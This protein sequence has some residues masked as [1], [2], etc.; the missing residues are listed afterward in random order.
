LAYDS[1]HNA[2]MKL[3]AAGPAGFE[4]LVRDVL[5]EVSGSTFRL[6]KSGPQ[7]GVDAVGEPVA[8][9]LAIGIEGKRY[10]ATTRLP[11]DALKS[12]L[13]D[14]AASFPALDL[15]VLATTRP[16]DGGD[17]RALREI[18]AD[19]GL[20]A[21][22]LDWPEGSAVPPPL[23]ILCA[24]APTSTAH[25]LPADP[26]V[27]ADLARVREDGFYLA[28]LERLRERL[29]DPVI[30]LAATRSK[31]RAWVRERLGDAAS[32]R[33]AFDSAAVLEKD[34]VKRVARPAIEGALDA[35]CAAPV[36]P[37]ALLG[38]EGMG[39]TWALF[40]WW[41]GKVDADPDFPLTVVLPAKDVDTFDAKA[42][43]AR[44]LHRATGVRDAAFWERRVARWST[45][46][47]DRPVILLAVDG[48][49]QNWRFLGWSDLVT[50]IHTPAWLGRIAVILTCRPDHWENRLKSLTDL[51][52]GVDVVQV[53][54]FDDA[55][56]DA[57]L[58]RHGLSRA[59][60]TPA[61]LELI[62]RPRLSSIAIER[63][64]ALS[65]GGEVT[66]ERLVYEDWR[67]RHP[68]AQRAMSHGEF[69]S[70]VTE[71]GRSTSADL[72]RAPLSRGELLSR[73][74]VDGG[75]PSED[76]QV[77]LSELVDGDWL[78]YD[79]SPHRFRLRAERVPAALG[80]TLVAD[81][82][83]AS[84]PEEA[85][86][87]FA[88]LL[89][90][91][92]D[93]DLAVSILRNA[94]TFAL[95]D[96][97]VAPP[98]KLLLLQR[99]IGAQNFSP[100][101]FEA[102]WRLLG[103]APDLALDVAEVDWF[104]EHGHSRADEVLV[105]GFGNAW[106]WTEVAGAVRSRLLDWFSRYWLD[107]LQGEVLGR[108]DGD[109]QA[110]ERREASRTRARAAER[111]RV[112]ERF[113][114]E[115]KLVEPD[116]QAWG[117]YRGVELLSWLPRAPLIDVFT[118]WAITRAIIGEFRQFGAMA[119]VLRW[120]EEDAAEAERAVLERARQLLDGG[121][122]IGREAARLLLDALATPAASQL[123]D[124]E[125]G[126]PAGRAPARL[127]WQDFANDRSR[128]QPLAA[129]ATLD[130]DPLDPL[131][132]L[133]SAWV[134]H[135]KRLASLVPDAELVA[136]YGIEA[137]GLEY[138]RA[139][140][141]RWVPDDLA[142][143]VRRRFAAAIRLVPPPAPER[144][145]L[146]RLWSGARG[147][148]QEEWPAL[149]VPSLVKNLPRSLLVLTDEDLAPWRN[150][151]GR[152]L[153]EGIKAPFALHATALAGA[154]AA[155]QIALLARTMPDEGLPDWS[156][157]LLAGPEQQDL[158]AIADLLGPE[159]P[160]AS[161][162]AW[163][164]Y[165]GAA[166]RGARPDGWAPLVKLFEHDDAA[167]RAAVL[168]LVA[169]HDDQVSAEAFYRSDWRLR[170]GMSRDE[171][172]YGSVVLTIAPSANDGSVLDR[173]HPDVLGS[174]LARHPTQKVYLDAFA[175]HVRL[176]LE[177]LRTSRS[178]VYPRSLLTVPR[179]WDE[180]IAARGDD[181]IKWMRPF[182]ENE[183]GL[184]DLLFIPE[185]FPL[186][187]SF[188]AVEDLVPGAKAGVVARALKASMS[189][190]M[191]MGALYDLATEVVGPGADGARELALAEANND[192][193]LFEL[194][195]GLQRNGQGEWLLEQI[196]RDL[197]GHTSG[198]VARGL[199][200][201]GFL[202]PSA[203]NDEWWAAHQAPLATGW[204]AEVHAAAYAE[205][206]RY[207]YV[208]HWARTYRNDVDDVAAFSAHALLVA[209]A[210][211][212]LLVGEERPEAD[213]IK[214][215]PWRRRL[216]WSVGWKDV[217]AAMKKREGSF[218][219]TFLATEPPLQNQT[220][221]RQ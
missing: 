206:R 25:H 105:K 61:L 200:L 67:H 53:P 172:A 32:A 214:G 128:S 4:G 78:E 133:P 106:R 175:E 108:V 121:G 118:A 198:R 52:G 113:G 161:L 80:L 10:G 79:A 217:R 168:K 138:A 62:R 176:E 74:G 219:K 170:A 157:R 102:Y 82:K 21:L 174:L 147:R 3:P 76:F 166:P 41:L 107:C 83:A 203:E 120:N 134:D 156:A 30:G 188:H 145:W 183:S 204:L 194:A 59:E 142:G 152:V 136:G 167:V 211:N 123:V 144:S 129:V 195:N 153:T 115:L 160:V 22:V 110:A 185:D 125:F 215:W 2:L 154:T 163:V 64:G 180:L 193:K 114:L 196:E 40:A 179:G 141:A 197:A 8:N 187:R 111:E 57:L 124:A 104:G 190:N 112:A 12:K 178:R 139:A 216:H 68:G 169:H 66:A 202:V 159:R 131:L 46:R 201:A 69:K 81:L 27:T 42:L 91:L 39:K 60:V 109:E 86:E 43:I 119:W 130:A 9:E 38:K 151:S 11:L 171:A 181:F 94:T 177:H 87:R 132:E 47:T 77:V 100:A 26:T 31:L 44:A 45:I 50:S 148:G 189:T 164:G 150:L 191:R 117:S 155:Q 116:R 184:H 158:D 35:W 140:L 13:R 135:L 55:E 28:E 5:T 103:L 20:D 48:L 18:G 85:D 96:Q 186:M 92:Q 212:R 98:I 16:I 1:L 209:G 33:M 182:F 101:D 51:D 54:Q 71:L 7:G 19:L 95:V 213:E 88:G 89:D 6:M 14:A 207:G 15:W 37:L 126:P 17:E 90:P 127:Q 218:E 173:V 34:G 149:E 93:S 72:E 56:L 84:C 23:A 36:R 75:G 162:L 49:N 146:S 58:L 24:A 70:F 99:W 192:K 143:L 29:R 137:S 73:L 208:Q 122:E 221:R 199:V 220:P 165:V 205:Y 63:R 97:E 210:D 65:D